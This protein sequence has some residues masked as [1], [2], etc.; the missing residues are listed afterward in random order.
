MT[1]RVGQDDGAFDNGDFATVDV[2]GDDGSADTDRTDRR[3]DVNVIGVVA[4]D[5]A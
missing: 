2:T 3:F 1:L 4:A 5:Q